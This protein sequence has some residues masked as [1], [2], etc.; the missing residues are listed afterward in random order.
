VTEW[1]SVDNG[2]IEDLNTFLIEEPDVKLVMI[3]T[4]GRF[5]GS[6][7][8]GK[9]IYQEESNTI[10]KIGKIADKHNIAIL[11]VHHTN[12]TPDV[13]DIFDKV[14]GSTG[15]TGSCDTVAIL[16]RENRHE[17]DAILHIAGRE[18]EAQDLALSFDSCS[19]TWRLLG[20][21][22]RFC[23]NDQRKQI[24]EYLDRQNNPRKTIE[25]AQ[26]L[27]KNHS[28]VRGLCSK[29]LKAGQIIQPARGLYTTINNVN[30]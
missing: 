1:K 12:K 9:Y 16:K 22:E 5:K 27:K 2:G 24:M 19:G 13:S 6:P 15:L 14:S 7:S 26:A 23:V 4:L 21:V 17:A 11:V 29:M 18:V 8:K 30:I 3:D 10:A 28:T 20:D 25:I